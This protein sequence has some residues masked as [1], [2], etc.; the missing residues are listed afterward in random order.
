MSK[1][2]TATK[3]GGAILCACARAHRL[4]CAADGRILLDMLDAV[5]FDLDGV[6]TRTAEL[7]AAA[8][9]ELFDDF[10]R[11]RIAQGADPFASFDPEVDYL[12]YVDGKPRLDGVRS[13]L[14]AR[15]VAIP[16][17]DEE[18]AVAAATVYG[19]GAQKDALFTQYLRS[20]GVDVF[21][22]TVELIRRLRAEGV[23]TGVV[24]SSRNG[25]EVL[26]A[27]NLVSLFD[28]RIDGIDADVLD[29]PGKP[30]PATFLR[31]M[32][33][34][35]A[36]PA[37]SVVVEDAA[38]EVEAGRRG[39]F[40]LVVGVDRGGNRE[41][42]MARGADLVVD[43]LAEVDLTS[44]TAHIRDKRQVSVAWTV[45]QEGFDPAR[46]HDMESIFA[47][48]NG[49]VG[50]RGALDTPLP[51]SQGDLFVAGVYDRKISKLPYSELEFVAADREGYPYAEIVTLPFPFRLAVT[52]DGVAV[53]M[54][55]TRWL[56]HRRTLD[57]RQGTLCSYVEY[58]IDADRRVTMRTRRCA[59]LADL[60]LLLQEVTVHLVNHSG[61]V[62]LSADTTDP[63]L[64]DNHPHLEALDCG[65][66][67]PTLGTAALQDRS[68]GDRDQ[69]SPP[70]SCWTARRLKDCAG[71]WPPG[72]ARH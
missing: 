53:G 59:S 11:R 26:R 1:R 36:V 46:E 31:A 50:V 23:K 38:S 25:R 2:S 15:G 54:A 61:E 21:A 5:L 16:E 10:L 44:L 9:K 60:H 43:D 13:F 35:G 72:S 24:T 49:Y 6:V 51:G 57:L 58:D 71:G 41:A 33:S 65:A 12:T 27:A 68:L 7:H 4:A 3:E 14:A 67:D 52:V 66:T 63:D 45:E 42:L 62:E 55:E 29:L 40:A 47:I 8:W 64:A 34:L 37:R 30:D 56:D 70:A 18:D 19:L 69:A 39:G 28:T 48:G 32:R 22:S 20:E 17:G